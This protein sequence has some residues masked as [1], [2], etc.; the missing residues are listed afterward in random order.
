MFEKDVKIEIEF[1][2]GIYNNKIREI[3]IYE[4]YKKG[5]KLCNLI[6]V[7]N[8]EKSEV[9]QILLDKT[10]NEIQKIKSLK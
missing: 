10:Q 2:K 9:L 7:F 3:I 1:K 5:L 8:I 4:L 6:E